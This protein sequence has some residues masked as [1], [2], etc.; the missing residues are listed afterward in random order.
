VQ[1]VIIAGGKGTRLKTRSAGLPKAMLDIGGKPLLA[2]QLALAEKHG[3]RDVL[4]LT[5]FGAEH[6]ESYF[7]DG[8]KLGL[9]IAYRREPQALGTAGAVL[10]AFDELDDTFLVMYGD[11]MLN[12]DLRRM[13]DAH[14]ENAAATLFLHPNDH[15]RDSDL[16]EVDAANRITALHPY[17][18]PPDKYFGNLVN[19]ALY[20]VRKSALAPFVNSRPHD[21]A[22]QLFPALLASGAHLH[23]YVSREYIKDAGTPK[24]LDRV[25]L[26]HAAGRIELGS[27]ETPAPAVFLD[28]DG[29]LNVE[30]GWLTAP[31]QVELLPG[32]ADAVR[33]IN[34]SGRLAVIITNQPVIARGD[35]TEAELKTIHDKLEWL[36]GEQHAYVDAIYYCPHHPHAGFDG[37][38]PELKFACTCRKPA[39]GLLEQ[40]A[41]E[42]NIDL[43]KSWMIGDRATDVQAAKTLG[44]AAA[45]VR[46]GPF[47]H[48]RM[49]A[50]Q[51]DGIFDDIL[52][53][54]RFILGS[55]PAR[56]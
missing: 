18:H 22:K 13:L 11:T 41:R 3:M 54:V 16:V 32:A 35:C 34:E 45:Q 38:R 37:E 8:S 21:F 42:L 28:R 15:P 33:A 6:I 2:H 23:G 9:R 55:Q 1:V 10:D 7:G 20:V 39:V 30:R 19:A 52:A 49:H 46:T 5:G 17:P 12:V 56:V 40:A 29:T 31:E 4:L 24:R 26:D 36:L 14:P 43:G 51:P 27:F 48:D 44:I 53:A 25:R 50:C 47:A